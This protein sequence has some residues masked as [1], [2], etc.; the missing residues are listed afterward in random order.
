SVSSLSSCTTYPA[1][2]KCCSFALV[3]SSSG[4]SC[5]TSS[6]RFI[7]AS[8]SA[9]TSPRARDPHEG[10]DI[11]SARSYDLR[12]R[13]SGRGHLDLGAVRG[14]VAVLVARLVEVDPAVGLDP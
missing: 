7:A 4:R 14:A 2:S 3:L 13:A 1:E 8:P 10:G 6:Y 12:R 11:R 9:P 5:S